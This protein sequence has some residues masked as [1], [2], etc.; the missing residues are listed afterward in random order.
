MIKG[1]MLKVDSSLSNH[2]SSGSIVIKVNKVSL[3]IL[4]SQIQL[5]Y[6]IIMK[7]DIAN[8]TWLENI[9]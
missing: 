5:F 6:C 9:L 2:T 4:N 7:I 3:G 8:D 1:S